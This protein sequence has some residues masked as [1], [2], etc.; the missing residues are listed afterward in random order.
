VG[1]AV[2]PKTRRDFTRWSHAGLL[3]LLLTGLAMFFADT[4][5]YLHNPAF[6]IKMA[7]VVAAL[8]WHFTL[9]R[10]GRFGAIMG[11][12][13][14]TAVVIAGRAIADFDIGPQ[15]WRGLSDQRLSGVQRR[16]SWRRFRQTESVARVSQCRDESRHGRQDC[17]RH[18]G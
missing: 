5:R 18:V 8:A 1:T 3:L 15:A 12:L 9:R 11:V 16:H 7:L 10:R 14:W 13:L 2:L 17:L 6:R 4:A